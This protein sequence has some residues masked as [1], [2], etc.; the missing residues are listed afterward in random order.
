VTE[1]PD[2]LSVGVAARRLGVDRDTLRRWADSGRIA[3]FTTPGG[4]RRFSRRAIDRLVADRQR[5][6]PASLASLASLGA[7]P[8]RL[9]AAYRRRNTGRAPADRAF[10]MDERLRESMRTDGR[11]LVESLLRWLDAASAMER[12]EV[13]AEA[14]GVA[15]ELG[16]RSRRAGL[17]ISDAVERFVAARG[18]LLDE[19]AAIARRRRLDAERTASIHRAASI[20]LDRLLVAF[21]TA[22][23]SG[24]RAR[25]RDLDR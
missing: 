16:R 24:R 19:L 11:R 15:T 14:I 2:W 9:T 3:A 17:T 22:H 21:V 18:P 8:E 5:A 25:G 10:G 20:L 1:R 13:E 12:A 4:H 7:T 23:E 6:D